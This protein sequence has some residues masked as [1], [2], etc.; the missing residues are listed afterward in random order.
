MSC[1]EGACGY[2]AFFIGLAGI[3]L[4]AIA[5]GIGVVLWTRPKAA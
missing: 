4:G 5:G 1:F 2:F 3:L